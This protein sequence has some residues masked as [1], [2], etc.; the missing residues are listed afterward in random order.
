[1]NAN[2]PV[3]ITLILLLVAGLPGR[4]F[5]QTDEPAP[6]RDT[7][8]EVVPLQ[9]ATATNVVEVLEQLLQN[10]DDVKV[11]GDA[12]GNSII[13]SGRGVFQLRQVL[14]MV[15][16]LDVV[17]RGFISDPGH[18]RVFPLQHADPQQAFRIIE[19]V[20]ADRNIRR[21]VDVMQARILARASD[22]DLELIQS[23]LLL[24]DNAVEA[25]AEGPELLEGASAG[26]S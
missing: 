1:M 10:E 24:I 5:A 3:L 13:V 25:T 17:P 11:I 9:H 26:G 15:K 6:D 12:S 20:V 8:F 18:L 7:F 4:A 16:S 23:V 14:E 19:T 2:H 21:E 22:E